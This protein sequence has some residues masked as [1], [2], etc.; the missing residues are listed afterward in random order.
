MKKPQTESK[1]STKLLL[2]VLC[3]D[4]FNSNDRAFRLLTFVEILPTYH[5]GTGR[6]WN[7]WAD[8]KWRS[9]FLSSWTDGLFRL[10]VWTEM[11]KWNWNIPYWCFSKI[12][13]IQAKWVKL[14]NILD[15]Q[16]VKHLFYVIYVLKECLQVP[17]S[18]LS[19]I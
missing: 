15:D 18:V 8:G 19:F 11:Q 9:Q 4:Y 5:C 7:M 1:M 10:S 3:A 17:Q 16:S 14:Y 12:W 2:G 6:N 13:K